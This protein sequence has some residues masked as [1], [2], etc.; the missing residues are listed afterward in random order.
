MLSL[1]NRCS[2]IYMGIDIITSS[3]HGHVMS[4]LQCKE[5]TPSNNKI[6]QCHQ[7]LPACNGSLI[8]S[9]EF[10]A[11]EFVGFKQIW[12]N[13]MEVELRWSDLG[14]DWF[15][16][17]TQNNTEEFSNMN[18]NFD[19]NIELPKQLDT[20]FL[21]LFHPCPTSRDVLSLVYMLMSYTMPHR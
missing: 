18:M 13:L 8:S 2:L 4:L 15:C 17:C 5:T 16:Y 21:R 6:S 19:I 9:E 1:S 10:V 14:A 12:A 20:A 3:M 11:L 7:L